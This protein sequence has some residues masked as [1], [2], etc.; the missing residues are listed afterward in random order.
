MS[1]F[2]EEEVLP[3]TATAR[4]SLSST[5]PRSSCTASPGPRNLPQIQQFVGNISNYS[6]PLK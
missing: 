4:G 1:S 5:G 2:T 6:I 3:A